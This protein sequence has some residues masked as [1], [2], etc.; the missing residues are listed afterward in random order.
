MW[1]KGA[2]DVQDD[3][4]LGIAYAAHAQDLSGMPVLYLQKVI[5]HES[6]SSV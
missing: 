6:V 3:L 4:S 1:R 5:I 2:I